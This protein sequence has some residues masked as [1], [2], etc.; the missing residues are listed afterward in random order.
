MLL[1]CEGSEAYRIFCKEVYGRNLCQA[2]MVDEEQLEKLIAVAGLKSS[3][4]VLDLGCGLGYSSEYLSDL[5]GANIFGIDFAAGAIDSAKLRTSLKRDRI[6]F[7]H[8]NL[9]SL[10]K[11]QSKF[12]CILSI[13]SL[14]F[15]NSITKTISDLK[16][17]FNPNGRLLIFYSSKA[18]DE[19]KKSAEHN[20]LGL[21]LGEMGF[22]FQAWDFTTNE[23]K[24]W[25]RTQVVANGLKNQFELE[26][27]IAIY[28][29]RIS[30]AQKNL[31]WQKAGVMTRYL[32][33]ATL[34][35]P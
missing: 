5:S 14:Y 33:H 19:T 3:D 15:V 1:Q 9:N 11:N 28:K 17:I 2:N 22:A 34:S 26:G 25:Q 18:K 7:Q 12:D 13:D 16:G 4:R 23:N 29:G 27:N 10:P 32:Y 8:G 6:R 24:I 30:E 31:E 21:A 20:E 35:K